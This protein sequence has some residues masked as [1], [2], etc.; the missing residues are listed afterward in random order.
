MVSIHSLLE[1]R[2]SMMVQEHRPGNLVTKGAFWADARTFLEFAGSVQ[3]FK[4][5]F[6]ATGQG[7]FRIGRPEIGA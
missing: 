2:R 7:F 3:F 6:G 5:L 4:S 1:I